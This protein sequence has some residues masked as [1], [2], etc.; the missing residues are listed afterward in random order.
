[1]RHKTIMLLA[2]ATLCLPLIS[3][4]QHGDFSFGVLMHILQ[5][6]PEDT[7]LRAAI[8]HAQDS[9]PAFIVVNGIKTADEACTDQRFRQRKAI[10]EAANTPVFLSMAGSDWVPCR[11]TRGRSNAIERLAIL[12]EQLYGDISW[13]GGR[14][15]AITRQSSIKAY[16]SYS[17]NTRWEFGDILFATLHL[18]APNNRYLAEAGRNGEFEDRQI[19]NRSWLRR[20]F[21]VAKR[22]RVSAIVLFCDGTLLPAQTT[23]VSPQ[24]DGFAEVRQQLKTLAP[25]FNGP[26]LVVQSRQAQARNTPL[27][28]AGAD[29]VWNRNL[30]YLRL[31]AGHTAIT[32]NPVLPTLFEIKS[33]EGR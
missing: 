9:S 33:D 14:Q 22:D 31:P 3:H 7:T 2:L 28:P 13:N 11:D 30:G 19:A 21:S 26:V 8:D 15:I 5:G 6:S 29:F 20:L 18:P 1:M 4:A 12:R 24:R 32:V 27:P 23:S 10:M 16:Q 25:K 17:E